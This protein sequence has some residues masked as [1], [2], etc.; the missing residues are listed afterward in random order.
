MQKAELYLLFFY[1]ITKTFFQK[2]KKK[3]Q[4]KQRQDTSVRCEK[5][6]FFALNDL[7]PEAVTPSV[8][9]TVGF[10]KDTD[11]TVVCKTEISRK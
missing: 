2:M 10:M 4:S 11:L 9:G 7:F 5:P 1:D 3:K 8:Q 6:L